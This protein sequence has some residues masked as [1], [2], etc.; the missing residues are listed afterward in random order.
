MLELD[1]WKIKTNA[2]VNLTFPTCLSTLM[3]KW[4]YT[5]ND[6]IVKHS[7]RLHRSLFVI[8]WKRH[9][10]V[11]WAEKVRPLI[12]FVATFQVPFMRVKICTH[13]MTIVINEFFL[14]HVLILWHLFP[15]FFLIGPSNWGLPSFVATFCP[16]FLHQEMLLNT[17]GK[18]DVWIVDSCCWIC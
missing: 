4:S 11:Q 16:A 12:F 15:I 10:D 8:N 18:I 7:D 3:I 13:S 9:I 5:K 1:S 14:W 17:L 6:V 2:C